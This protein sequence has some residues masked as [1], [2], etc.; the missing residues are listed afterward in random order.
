MATRKSPTRKKTA[1]KST[2]AT[3]K[4]PAKRVRKP[5]QAAKKASAVPVQVPV[6]PK[7]PQTSD[8][9]PH[10]WLTAV[11]GAEEKKAL[12]ITVLDLR[13][14]T[15]FCDFFVI[16]SGTNPKQVQAIAESV[17]R[18]L[19]TIN[20]RANAVE[21]YDNAEWI[22]ADYGDFIV[23]IFS[24]KAREFYDLERLWRAA[25]VCEIPP[26]PLVAK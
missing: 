6:V 8:G 3:K 18:E 2:A 26:A 9:R 1:R 11:R 20:E 16:A 22:L 21:G 5:A 4:A 13:E 23:H 7:K 12:N 17:D 14:V 15:S 24:E 19:R 25:H 10:A